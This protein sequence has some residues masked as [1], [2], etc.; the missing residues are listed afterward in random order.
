M[1]NRTATSCLWEPNIT[2]IVCKK[3]NLLP[4][5]SENQIL[6]VLYGKK[7]FFFFV[8]F[9]KTG[10]FD[11]FL[12]DENWK[13]NCQFFVIINVKESC[14]EIWWKTNLKCFVCIFLIKGVEH[15]REF[16]ARRNASAT[17]P[18]DPS[19][20]TQV[21]ATC[22]GQDSLLCSRLQLSSASDSKMFRTSRNLKHSKV[23]ACCRGSC[24]DRHM[25]LP[26]GSA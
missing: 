22:D 18:T 21:A 26:L 23:G 17:H 11:C 7:F 19:M 1:L 24:P 5:S 15:E 14:F 4:C 8:M 9:V 16:R 25:G 12:Y 6:P 20:R 3:K 13:W 10:I 2:G